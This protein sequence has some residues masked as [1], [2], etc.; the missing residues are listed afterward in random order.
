MSTGVCSC[1]TI[2]LSFRC[3]L[4][5]VK[6]HISFKQNKKKYLAEELL[7]VVDGLP[8]H[9]LVLLDGGDVGLR[10]LSLVQQTSGDWVK[11]MFRVVRHFFLAR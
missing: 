9:L 8:V 10:A 5:L 7:G 2:R 3:A 4:F 11:G 1:G 6:V